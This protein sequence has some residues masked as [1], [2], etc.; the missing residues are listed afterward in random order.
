MRVKL[1]GLLLSILALALLSVPAS[2]SSIFL[3]FDENGNATSTFCTTTCTTTSDPGILVT[4]PQSGLLALAYILPERVQP[5]DAG[6]LEPTTHT[7]TDGLRFENFGTASIMFFFSDNTDGVNNVA[8]T[9]I[10]S[11]NFANNTVFENTDG[12]FVYKPAPNIYVGQSDGEVPEPASML[13]LG[14]GLLVLAGFAR[15]CMKKKA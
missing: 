5:G 4:D 15:K 12:S 9:G 7:L 14:S 10:P 13:L 2:A 1:V 6:V 11:G 3:T 8:D